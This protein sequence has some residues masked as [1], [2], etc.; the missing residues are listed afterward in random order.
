MS[1]NKGISI[2]LDRERIFNLVRNEKINPNKYI[3][4]KSFN[5]ITNKNSIGN[6]QYNQA[7][8]RF[9][10]RELPNILDIK[11]IELEDFLILLED[12]IIKILKTKVVVEENKDESKFYFYIKKSNGDILKI[13]TSYLFDGY[14]KLFEKTKLVKV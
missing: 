8:K 14:I 5:Q 4:N 13:S 1:S 10:F 7:S 3:D 2:K 6:Y 11:N 9:S 12:K